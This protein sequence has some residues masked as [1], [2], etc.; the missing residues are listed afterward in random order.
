MF[1]E[2]S[3]NEEPTVLLCP[4]SDTINEKKD[5]VMEIFIDKSKSGILGKGAYGCVRKGRIRYSSSGKTEFPVA[6][7]SFFDKEP[8]SQNI[9]REI[10]GMT[11]IPHHPNVLKAKS[12]YLDEKMRCILVSEKMKSNLYDRLKYSCTLEKRV[13]WSLQLLCAVDHLHSNGFMHR[14]IKLENVFIDRND[15]AV[16]GDMGMCRFFESSEKPTFTSGV[17]TLWT[18][19][20]ELCFKSLYCDKRSSTLYSESIDN[21]S[22]GITILGIFASTYF[23]QGKNE[24]DVF[25]RMIEL[26]GLPPTQ[27]WNEWCISASRTRKP[28]NFV[29]AKSHTDEESA[30]ALMQECSRR[31]IVIHPDFI[32]AIIPLLRVDPKER[33]FPRDI[34]NNAFFKEFELNKT[35]TVFSKRTIIEASSFFLVPLTLTKNEHR[36]FE[37]ETVTENK[38]SVLETCPTRGPLR[39]AVTM[40]I[41]SLQDTL[42]LSQLTILDTILLWEQIRDKINVDIKSEIVL[43]AACTSLVSKFHER[44]LTSSSQILRCISNSS[45]GSVNLFEYEVTVLKTSNCNLVRHKT[46]NLFLQLQKKM[47]K[48]NSE[49]ENCTRRLIDVVSKI[50]SSDLSIEEIINLSTAQETDEEESKIKREEK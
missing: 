1:S 29:L 26:F 47:G 11:C 28:K 37:E 9:I 7:K 31:K 15:N 24:S 46:I 23:V 13:K 50:H 4:I 19:P 42:C 16:L 25:M 41:L 22:L 49:S 21:W 14:D 6:F 36:L 45:A 2:H 38:A 3:H 35:F 33:G 30:Q 20:P 17:C 44:N 8:F 48:R 39:L 5:D 32:R 27:T 10:V 43:A 34:V 40:W 18:R 12:I